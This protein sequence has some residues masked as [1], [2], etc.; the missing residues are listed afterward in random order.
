MLLVDEP[1][2]GLDEPGK[3]ALL[4]LFDAASQR[5]A[6][7][8]IATHELSFVK[9]VGRLLALRDG[10]LVYDGAPADTD[11]HALVLPQLTASLRKVVTNLSPGVIATA[12][13]DT[14]LSVHAGIRIDQRL[15]LRS[16]GSR[17]QAHR[18]GRGRLVGR[19]HRPHGWRRHGVPNPREE[20]RRRVAEAGR[21]QR[22]GHGKVEDEASSLVLPA[23]TEAGCRHRAEG[24]RQ[25]EAKPEPVSEPSGWAIAPEPATTVAPSRAGVQPAVTVQPG[26][27]YQPAAPPATQPAAP[28]VHRS[29]SPAARAAAAAAAATPA[30]A[31][32][33]AVPAG[34]Y[35][36]PA[37]RFELRYWDG[38]TWTEHVSRA[39]Q[40]FTDPPVA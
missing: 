24:R 27:S 15:V 11:V 34:W 6:T 12:V 38:S 23:K 21:H 9:Q 2:V 5:G 20:W 31:P 7:L 36:D 29:A 28:A 16:L 3:Q 1:F 19:C 39:G 17:H 37:G 18:Q 8:V 22:A 26:S 35:A 14:T 4:R 10:T 40:Q 32:A 33:P 30:A 25:A 13:A